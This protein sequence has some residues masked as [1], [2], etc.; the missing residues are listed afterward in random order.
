MNSNPPD[1]SRRL[2]SP[3]ADL[4]ATAPWRWRE[5]WAAGF[6]S[7]EHNLQVLDRW[8]M[9]MGAVVAFAVA[10]LFVVPTPADRETVWGQVLLGVL[11]L[12]CGALTVWAILGLRLDHA[13][14]ISAFRFASKAGVPGGELAGTIDIPAGFD[15]RDGATLTLACLV[16]DHKA[17]RVVHLISSVEDIR[18]TRR[19]GAPD[20][21]E[22]P[23]KFPIP[24][25]APTTTPDDG[26]PVVRWVAI[27][28][29]KPTRDALRMEF[30]VPILPSA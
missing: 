4:F 8:F 11:L 16:E 18:A 22:I 5:E 17:D 1:P 25:E 29:S 9:A 23:A 6:V 15:L 14:G 2:E 3:P 12:L 10:N 28:A 26:N 21:C 19:A 20:R 30:E 27:L 7:A 24:R 13:L